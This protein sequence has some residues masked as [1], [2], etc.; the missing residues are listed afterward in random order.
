LSYFCLGSVIIFRPWGTE[1]GGLHV[2]D[3]LEGGFHVILKAFVPLLLRA[4]L[5]CKKESRQNMDIFR[6]RDGDQPGTDVMIFKIFSPKNLVK[7]LAFLTQNKAKL[8][9]N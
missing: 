8:K 6:T 9:K 2:L 3:V 7:I 4:E 1:V 5:I